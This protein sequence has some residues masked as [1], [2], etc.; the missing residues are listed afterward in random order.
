[1]G[2][3]KQGEGHF[4]FFLAVGRFSSQKESIRFYGHISPKPQ[5]IDVKVSC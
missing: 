2:L 4:L 1:M 3:G 5:G